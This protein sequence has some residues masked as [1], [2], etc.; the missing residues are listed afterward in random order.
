MLILIDV[1]LI[2]LWTVLLLHIIKCGVNYV[3]RKCKERF[4]CFIIMYQTVYHLVYYLAIFLLKTTLW[5]PYI[6]GCLVSTSDKIF[7]KQLMAQIRNDQFAWTC[8]VVDSLF[9]L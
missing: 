1:L 8:W 4:L 5:K 2:M 7:Y 3:V 6:S 9:H